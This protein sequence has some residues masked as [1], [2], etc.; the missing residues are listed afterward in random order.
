MVSK[1][2]AQQTLDFVQCVFAIYLRLAMAPHFR[3]HS[4]LTGYKLN[5][6][7]FNVLCTCL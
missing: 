1:Q 5:V 2:V 6:D 4:I 7:L 3:R